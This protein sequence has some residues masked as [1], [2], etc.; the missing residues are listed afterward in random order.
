MYCWKDLKKAVEEIQT[1]RV[2]F[3]A[4]FKMSG[5]VPFN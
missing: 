3:G 1:M 4:K 5:S 2:W